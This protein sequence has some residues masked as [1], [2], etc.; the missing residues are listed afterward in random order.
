MIPHNKP[1]MYKEDAIQAYETVLSGWLAYGKKSTEVENKLSKLI[2]AT[3]KNKAI[4]CSNGTTALYLA[5]YA[6]D[7]KKTD[8]VILPTYTCTAV[9]NAVKQIGAKA[10]LVDIDERDLNLSFDMVKAKITKK[11]KAIIVIHTYGIAC[12]IEKF[13][14]FNIPI[15]EDCSQSLGSKFEDGTQAGSKGDISIFS[16]YA[17]KMATGGYGGAVLSKDDSFRSKLKDYIEFDQPDK[18][19][20]RFNFLLSDI[21]AS[22]ISS[23][24]DKL[25]YFL[26]KRLLIANKYKEVIQN[27]WLKYA[28][29]SG[30]NYYRF[31]LSFESRDSLK[32]IYNQFKSN[33]IGVI[34]PLENSE[35]LHS[36]VGEEKKSFLIA[37]KASYTLLSIPI[38]PC[39]KEEE[40]NLIITTLKEL[41]LI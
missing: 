31:I 23:Q 38:Y 6:L 27:K 15:I 24:L 22:I 4:V 30:Q 14:E 9:L 29:N 41:Q 2:Y 21:N 32:R 1:C 39:L 12:E 37:E 7:I 28:N 18:F 3:D 8:E 17:T 34:N 5:L 25:D 36:Y 11:I 33:N 20:P 16:F 13:Q 19:Y 10:I 26:E 40:L 35:L